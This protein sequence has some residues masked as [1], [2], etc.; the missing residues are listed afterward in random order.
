MIFYF[1]FLMNYVYFNDSYI[2]DYIKN[3]FSEVI[4]YLVFM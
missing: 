4:Y 2:P 3:Y 1:S